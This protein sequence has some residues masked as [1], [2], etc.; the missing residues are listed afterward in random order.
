MNLRA[1]SLAS[2]FALMSPM[3]FCQSALPDRAFEVASIKPHQG[4]MYRIGIST[5]GRTLTADA[6]SVLILLMYAYDVKN[7]QV[8]GAPSLLKGDNTR[9]DVVAKAEEEKPTQAEFRRMLQS[10]LADRFRLAIH[11]ESREMPV[12]ALVV[13]KGGPKFKESAPDADEKRH[14]ELTG[15]NYVVTMPNATMTDVVNAVTDSI[16]DRPVVDRTGLAGTYNI[17]LTYSPETSAH[18]EQGPDLSDI[19]VF[20]ALQRQLGLKLVPEKALVDVVVI[21]HA[22]KPSPN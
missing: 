4:P 22:E 8:T 12:Y 3:I 15:R 17:R 20:S 9:Y 16:L 19:D 2:L 21:D 14:T 13:A 6:A 18:R 5:I 7:Y 10:L 1:T 11:R